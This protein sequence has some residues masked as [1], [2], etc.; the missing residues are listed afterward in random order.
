MCL[1]GCRFYNMKYQ[2]LSLVVGLFGVQFCTGQADPGMPKLVDRGGVVQLY[3]DDK[4]FL[5][6][7][8]EVNNSSSSNIEY[9]KPIWQQARALNFN[10]LVT[11][12]SW[13]LVEPKE[14]LFD[15]A[16]VDSLIGNARKNDLHLV[17]LW[18]ASWKNGMSSYI[19]LWVKENYKK[20]PRIKL[21]QG[22][23][24]EV[25][26]TLAE[27][28]WRAD[29]RA[30]GSLMKHIR[31]IDGK[32]HTVI[33]VQVENEVGVLGDSR[34]R[35]DE[36]NVAFNGSVPKELIHYLE[37]NKD[38]LLPD[39]I[40]KYWAAGGFRTSGSWTE[41]FGKTMYCDELFMAWNY[42]G[43]VNRVAE[44][45][46]KEYP[47]PMYANCWLD[48]VDDPKP[49]DFPSGCPEARLMDVWRSRQTGIDMVSPDLY[50]AEFDFRC[51][52][53]T[54]LGNPL[55][56]PEMNSSD[57]GARNIFV[58]IGKYNAIG[59]S[60][61]GIDHLRDPERSGFT[62]S[63][64]MVGQL[65]GRILEAQAKKELIG[66]VVDEKNP[67]VTC[68]MNGYRLEISLDELFGHKATLGYG[69]VMADGD[70]SFIGSGSGFR[71]RFFPGDKNSKAAV[72]IGGSDEGVFK[73]GVWIA[74]RRLNGDEDDQG[75]AWRFSS[76]QTAIEKCMVYTYE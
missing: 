19:P 41:V 15:F 4:P 71:V 66:F 67:V 27:A 23:T 53:Y 40:K 33:M 45:G 28:N 22:Y 37:K 17:I 10:T 55:F 50:A 64:G 1:C 49:G 74:G 34:D 12:V 61:F 57:D 2:I 62:K 29:A 46:K 52:Q 39:G 51:R 20:Y 9:L 56:I 44:A 14:G 76:F 65:A 54:R 16:L 3:V 31:A 60:P 18:L 24:Q 47:I 68:E 7:G 43:Y 69:L 70:H 26:S 11:P 30:F 35:S 21:Q 25:L 63:Y 42:A 6:L 75:R 72:G 32:E 58:A 59:V 36:A 5:V 13:E 73:D 48:P 38:S 8:G